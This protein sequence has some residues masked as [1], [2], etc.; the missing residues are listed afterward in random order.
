MHAEEHHTFRQSAGL[1][2]ATQTNS[3]LRANTHWGSRFFKAEKQWEDEAVARSG[4]FLELT[5]SEFSSS[6]HMNVSS[7]RAQYQ[8]APNT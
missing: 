8:S 4:F 2:A 3:C 5:R 6:N 7:F 1:K